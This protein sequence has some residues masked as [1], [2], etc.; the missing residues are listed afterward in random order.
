MSVNGCESCE[1]WNII[2][3]DFD[4]GENEVQPKKTKYVFLIGQD[5]GHE[6]LQVAPG[7]DENPYHGKSN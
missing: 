5:G 6:G 4:R 1:R 3:S 2:V 7:V